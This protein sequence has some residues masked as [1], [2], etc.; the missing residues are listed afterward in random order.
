MN[1]RDL[2]KSGAVAVGALAL[3]AVASAPPCSCNLDRCREC[4]R[5]NIEE[6]NA[7]LRRMIAESKRHLRDLERQHATLDLE[8]LAAAERREMERRRHWVLT[9][10]YDNSGRW[11]TRHLP[12]RAT[13]P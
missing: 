8:E 13:T 2:I 7:A 12:A 9:G 10:E 4:V 1:R 11:A 5:R 3:P 6:H